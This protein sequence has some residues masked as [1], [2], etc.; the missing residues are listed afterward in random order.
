MFYAHSSTKTTNFCF[1]KNKRKWVECNY[2]YTYTVF[3][4]L[5]IKQAVINFDSTYTYM[6]IT[7][8]R[9]Q[10]LYFYNC[11]IPYS[12]KLKLYIVLDE[13]VKYIYGHFYVLCNTQSQFCL[14]CE[15]APH[16]RSAQN[17]TIFS[18]FFSHFLAFFIFR[19][20]KHNLIT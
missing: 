17:F 18:Y 5:I 1:V 20:I 14:R 7:R 16:R 15:N 10:T 8:W 12:Y 3:L 19:N 4:N 11:H 9:Y 13:I 2:W 6:Y